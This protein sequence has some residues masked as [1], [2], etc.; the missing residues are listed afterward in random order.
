MKRK[1]QVLKN[2]A[3]EDLIKELNDLLVTSQQK[4]LSKY[5]RTIFPPVFIVGCPRSG[6]T[7]LIQWLAASGCFAY[8]SNFISRFYGSPYI[9]ALIQQML[10]D[11][12]FAFNDEM[13]GL[14]IRTNEWFKSHLGKTNGLLSPN[15]FWYFWRRYFHYG[16]IQ[17]LDD[18]KLKQI[19]INSLLSELAAL[20]DVFKLPLLMKALIVNWNL[21]F[22]AEKIE[23]S[24]FLYIKRNSF[25]N[26]QSLLKARLKY[27]NDIRKWYSFKP[28]E[29]E[30]LK[31]EDLFTQVAG[32]VY[33]TNQA[34]QKGLSTVRSSR[35]LEI[36]YENFCLSPKSI[37]ENLSA[38]MN[39]NG[40]QLEQKYN[41]PEH[42]EC[43]NELK[44]TE[45]EKEKISRAY[46]R[47]V[48][49]NN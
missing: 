43:M 29:Y 23:S 4:T 35:W 41:G 42:F 32:Q 33:F 39:K 3:L 10:L 24:V 8:P 46:H 7:L 21:D 13:S 1:T 22:L 34:I 16:E 6:T 20:E 12:Q 19:D 31:K 26:I 28:V 44:V 45:S 37:W 38:L 17:Y 15:E 27:F 48:Q 49:K 40:Y 11:P 25:F 9:G 47:L 2:S 5:R 36:Q 30:F 14:S 18:S